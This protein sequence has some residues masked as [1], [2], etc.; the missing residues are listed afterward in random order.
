MVA[1]AAAR[2]EAVDLD[3]VVPGEALRRAGFQ[4]A[5]AALLLAS[6]A[7]VGRERRAKRGTPPHSRCFRRA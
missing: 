3:A 4:A 1:D 5:A 7:F 6:V 2:A